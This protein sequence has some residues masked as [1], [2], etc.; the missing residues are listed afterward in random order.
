MR[1]FTM[2][3]LSYGYE[4]VPVGELKP[5]KKGRLRADGYTHRIV[6][7]EAFVVKRIYKDF[8]D[9]KSLTSIVKSLNQEK[10]PCKNLR[11][12]WNV[13][14]LSGI[15]KNEKYK[16]LYIWNRRTNIKDP[17]TGKRKQIIRPKDEWLIIEKPE[18]KIIEETI[19]NKVQKRFEEL[20]NAHPI[21]K[22]TGKQKSYVINNPTHLLSG[23][24]ICG[25]CSGPIVLVSGKGSCYYGCHNAN[26]K[27]CH[28]KILV[29]RKK[30]ESFFMDALLQKVLKPEHIDL[31]YK[32]V[33]VE[34][35]KQF[36]HI[37]EDIRFKKL[38]LNKVENR[39]YRFIEFI[40]EGKSTSSV[41]TALEDA[42]TNAKRI[43][44]DLEFLEQTKNEAFEPPPLEWINHRISKIQDV[45]ESKTEKSAL[46]LRKL[47]G[48]IILIPT[49]PDIGRPYYYA[50]SKLKAFALL[51][52][53][54]ALDGDEGSNWS[55]WRRRRDA[56]RGFFETLTRSIINH[57]KTQFSL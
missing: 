11:R 42:E 37:P 35:Q 3:G 51:D 43:K 27:R 4:S 39:I 38:E 50:K 34:I 16:G 40:A 36:S 33:A 5:D 24:V 31:I 1:G 47:T 18:I 2:G 25:E 8:I 12:G 55:N 46:L 20:K 29:N 14:T 54:N 56:L 41:A 13:S 15:L 7:E 22:G 30:L 45:L 57:K 49:T 19:W 52:K 26:R 23:N 48:K 53:N 32:K 6:P 10:V 17:M 9:G 21:P 28:N 44:N